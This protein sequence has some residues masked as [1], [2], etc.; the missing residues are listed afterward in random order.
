MAKEKD[1][2]V[3]DVE[4]A[5]TRTEIYFEENKKS[6]TIIGVAILALAGL[7]VGYKF[8]YVPEQDAAA[9]ERL[10]MIENAFAKDSFNVV[11]TGNANAPGAEEIADEYSATPSGNLARYMAGISYLRTGKYQEA[12]DNLEDFE[13][14]DQVLSSIALGATGDAY[15]ELGNVEEAID[16]YLKAAGN[17]AN[18]FTSPLYLKKAGIAYEEKGQF[19]DAVKVYEQIKNDYPESAEGREIEKY[20]ARA[21]T[22][23]G[24]GA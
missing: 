4:G 14:D 9:K 13:S 23:A 16:H 12:I 8:W 24:T 5:L 21:K 7:F 15:M 3:V 17:N 10:F 1:A 11:L 19:Q 22:L 18:K 6:L 2:P 20:L